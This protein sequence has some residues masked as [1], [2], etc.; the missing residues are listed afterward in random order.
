LKDLYRNAGEI[1]ETEANEIGNA[2][3]GQCFLISS[4]R[5]RTSFKVVAS[6][7]VQELFSKPVSSARLAELAG[8]KTQ[9]EVG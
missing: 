1:N 8:V 3:T 9:E 6:D 4:P 5:E 2:G 7:T